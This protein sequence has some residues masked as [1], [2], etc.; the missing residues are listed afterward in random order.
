MVVSPSSEL[1]AEEVQRELEMQLKHF[2]A[3]DSK[4]GLLLGCSVP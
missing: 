4:A 2:E 1:V 3:I